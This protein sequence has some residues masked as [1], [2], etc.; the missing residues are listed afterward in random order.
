MAIPHSERYH[1]SNKAF[2]Y[3]DLVPK[4]VTTY[5][6]VS[7]IS[8]N[9]NT[10]VLSRGVVGVVS[11]QYLF[12][13]KENLFDINLVFGTGF[14]ATFGAYKINLARISISKD[15][16]TI[17]IGDEAFQYTSRNIDQLTE[18]LNDFGVPTP[19]ALS[20]TSIVESALGSGLIANR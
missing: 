7:I 18:D 20:L 8:G 15:V 14:S 9:Q 17:Q 12:D 13:N 11:T 10:L 5:G 3:Y 2:G 4:G 1:S 16:F 19:I 6:S